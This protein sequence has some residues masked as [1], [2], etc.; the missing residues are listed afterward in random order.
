MYK[1][2]LWYI[3]CIIQIRWPLIVNLSNL[4]YVDGSKYNNKSA[5]ELWDSISKNHKPEVVQK[6]VKAHKVVESNER[7]LE[8]LITEISKVNVN[9]MYARKSGKS[10]FCICSPL[11]KDMMEKFVTHVDNIFGMCKC[12]EYFI[13]NI[14]VYRPI[15]KKILFFFYQNPNHSYRI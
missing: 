7:K 4:F 10:T 1:S 12:L 13:Q 11:V 15:S 3:L 6:T 14:Y 8:A 5:S 2:S 9:V